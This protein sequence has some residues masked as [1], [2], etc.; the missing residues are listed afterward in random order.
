MHSIDISTKRRRIDYWRH[1]L[2]YKYFTFSKIANR[3]LLCLNRYFHPP[4]RHIT[5][6]GESSDLNYVLPEWPIDHRL[7]WSVRQIWTAAV[8]TSTTHSTSDY[9]TKKNEE[10]V[11]KGNVPTKYIISLFQCTI[12]VFECIWSQIYLFRCDCCF[13]FQ[14]ELWTKHWEAISLVESL[15]RKHKFQNARKHGSYTQTLAK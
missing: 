13:V 15:P 5:N 11:R 6:C 4:L 12:N 14:R 3:V 10:G 1:I 7:A 2:I 9:M 8:L